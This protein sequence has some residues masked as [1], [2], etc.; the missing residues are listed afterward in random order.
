[1]AMTLRLTEEVDAHLAAY[2]EL[3]GLSKQQAM[4]QL[5]T[6]AELPGER[7]ARLKEI[8]DMVMVRDAELMQRLADA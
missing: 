7:E 8:F 3:Q 4:M 5:I 2:A 1:M 6:Q